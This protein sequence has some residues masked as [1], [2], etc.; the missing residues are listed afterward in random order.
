MT[1]A[2]RGWLPFPSYNP[3][4]A[5]SA[6]TGTIH[7]A[8]QLAQPRFWSAQND[9]NSSPVSTSAPPY[10]VNKRRTDFKKS[11]RISV[12]PIQTTP[13]CPGQT[14]RRRPLKRTSPMGLSLLHAAPKSAADKKFIIS[15]L[16]KQQNCSSLQTQITFHASKVI[17]LGTICQ[18]RKE[19]KKEKK[20]D[21]HVIC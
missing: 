16:L 4:T 13:L 21:Y 20:T 2:Q 10:Q 12:P 18:K 14:C 17:S 9:D 1:Q 7:W 3:V 19:E 8:G 11:M 5:L 15:R 6:E